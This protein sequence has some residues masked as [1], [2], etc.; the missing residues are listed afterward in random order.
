MKNYFK[1]FDSFGIEQIDITKEFN[2]ENSNYKNILNLLLEG[3]IYPKISLKD[4][5]A[6]KNL[7]ERNLDI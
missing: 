6:G 4:A 1:L 2:L 7:N 5:I 3:K